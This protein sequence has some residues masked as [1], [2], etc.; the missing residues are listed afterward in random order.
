M[1][2]LK[3][4]QID[5]VVVDLPTAFFIT[6]VQ[7]PKG[8]VVGQFE[9]ESQEYF[10]MAFE[11]GSAL[12]ECVNLAL[13]EMKED[14]TLEAIHEEWLAGATNAPVP[15]VARARRRASGRGA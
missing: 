11:K 14:G 7:I 3:S 1:Q 10:A 9:A 4:G 15:D 5:G 6:A 2:D 8:V 12:V 13:Q